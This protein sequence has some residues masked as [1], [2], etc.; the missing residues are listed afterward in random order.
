MSI[1][2]LSYKQTFCLFSLET[3]RVSLK[4]C[5]SF[6][7]FLGC[8]IFTFILLMGFFFFPSLGQFLSSVRGNFLYYSCDIILYLWSPD[9]QYLTLQVNFWINL[10]F[11]VE[12]LKFFILLEKVSILV[13]TITFFHFL[14][15]WKNRCKQLYLLNL[16]TFSCLEHFLKGGRHY[17]TNLIIRNLHVKFYQNLLKSFSIQKKL[18]Y[19]KIKIFK[20]FPDLYKSIV[21]MLKLY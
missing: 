12:A 19:N 9:S 4:L 1:W 20:S 21:F 14:P 3:F 13:T 17:I 7:G 2:W 15:K 6:M 8:G 11:Q 5:K 16:T 10:K 18:Q